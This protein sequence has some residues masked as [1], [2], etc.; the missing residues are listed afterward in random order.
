MT[1]YVNDCHVRRCR[2]IPTRGR[3]GNLGR[4]LRTRLRSSLSVSPDFILSLFN[5][6]TYLGSYSHVMS[7][8][9]CTIAVIFGG[10]SLLT[11]S[12]RGV[13]KDYF[14]GRWS[15]PRG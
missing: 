4:Y 8:E 5:P 11:L 13:V 2:Q 10:T 12:P 15:F 14:G 1:V 3:G 7:R 6:A 9:S